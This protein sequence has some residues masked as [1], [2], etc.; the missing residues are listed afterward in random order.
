MQPTKHGIYRKP[1]MDFSHFDTRNY[2]TRS[3]QEGYSEWAATYEDIVLDA[4][5]LR[6]LDKIQSVDWAGVH[7]AADLACGTGRTG[8]WLKRQG[9]PTL[10]GLDLTPAMLAGARAKG[11]Y[12]QLVLGDVLNTPFPTDGYDLAVISLADEHLADVRPLYREAAQITRPDGAFVLVGY[13]PF[14]LMM[15]GMP[16]H[17]NSASGE[18]VAIQTYVHLFGDHVQAARVAGWSLLEMREGLVDDEWLA[19]KPKWKPYQNRPISF[20]MVWRKLH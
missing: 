11:V 15:S 13:H 1:A 19:K 14:F 12:R 9:I 17:F 2:P 18:P 10:D 4:M 6:L 3:V 8:V 20:A 5:D 16:T 7:N